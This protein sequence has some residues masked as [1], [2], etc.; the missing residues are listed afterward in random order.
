MSTAD[1]PVIM[2]SGRK[3]VLAC[4]IVACGLA[5]IG[6]I[7]PLPVSL[8]AA[9]VFITILSLFVFGSFK[10]QIHKNALT[11]GMVLV[12]VSTFLGLESTAWHQQVAADGWWPW[13]REHV[14]SF[15][16]STS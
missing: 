6:R 8:V 5:V 13:L 10:Y 4:A 3:F 15:H 1:S 11:Y 7:R 14:L 2:L 16:G 9:E 12:I